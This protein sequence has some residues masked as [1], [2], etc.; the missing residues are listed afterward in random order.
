MNR[1]RFLRVS[2]ELIDFSTLFSLCTYF[3]CWYRVV[4][5]TL[6]ADQM[7]IMVE[8]SR[9]FL[10]TEYARGDCGTLNT[11][12]TDSKVWDNLPVSTS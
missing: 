5:L 10:W 2:N 12:G 1:E 6:V 7:T 9:T 11:Q 3:R 4:H 8:S